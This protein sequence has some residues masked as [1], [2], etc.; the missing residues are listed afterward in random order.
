MNYCDWKVLCFHP[1]RIRSA[2][3]PAVAS[4]REHCPVI[5]SHLK[6]SPPVALP[7]ALT[8]LTLADG[9]MFSLFLMLFLMYCMHRLNQTV[10]VLNLSL[11][12][13]LFILHLCISVFWTPGR[14]EAHLCA[15]NW[16]PH[17]NPN[18]RGQRRAV[19]PTV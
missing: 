19:C 7:V 13:F 18:S 10:L 5:W 12:L 6:K 14:L 15:S 2:L 8:K 4:H 17:I 16:D 11:L 1:P 3:H 9:R